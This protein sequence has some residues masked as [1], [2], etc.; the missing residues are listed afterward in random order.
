MARIAREMQDGTRHD[1]VGVRV[2]KRRPL[3]RLDAEVERG[4]GDER[5]RHRADLGDRG[6]IAVIAADVVALAEQ[7]DKIA[8]AAAT[9]I[10]DA[11]AASDASSQQLIE[12]V[13]VDVAELVLQGH[14]QKQRPRRRAPSGP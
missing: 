3:D 4:S 2:W 9:G 6:R 8:P 1:D 12:N 14:R 5:R 10:K 13:D 7:I 11:H